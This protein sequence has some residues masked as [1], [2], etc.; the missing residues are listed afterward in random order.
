M[1][2]FEAPEIMI[3]GGSSKGV[4]FAEVAK[5]V[6]ERDVKRVILIGPEGVSRIREALVAQGYERFSELEKYSM[7]E[8]VAEA[9]RYAE[10]GDVVVLSPACASFDAFA[11]YA[12]RG[13]AF[14]AAVEKLG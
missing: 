7:D 1:R 9:G 2:S 3:M 10:A 5:T 14:V 13:E 6:V 4:D 12:A 11:N 8:V